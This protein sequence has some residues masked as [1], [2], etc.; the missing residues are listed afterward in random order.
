[1]YKTALDMPGMEN[2]EKFRGPT[3]RNNCIH[4]HM[5]H[6]AEQ[7]QASAAGIP[8]QEIVLRYPLPDNVGI[9]INPQDGCKIER[10]D[11]A[12]P[13]EKAGLRTG[14]IITHANGQ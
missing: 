6:D 7:R 11:T 5:I 13:A 14:D 1:P 8:N 3:A 9:H 2:K 4:C 10:V 12:S